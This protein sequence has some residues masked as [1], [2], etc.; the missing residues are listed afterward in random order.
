MLYK[1]SELLFYNFARWQF[2]GIILCM[3]A[4][5]ICLQ[6]NIDVRPRVLAPPNRNPSVSHGT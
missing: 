3:Y 6:A 1:A 4:K 5:I 2:T